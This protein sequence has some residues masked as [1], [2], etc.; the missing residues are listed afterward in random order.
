MNEIL[1]KSQ[2]RRSFLKYV[3]AGVALSMAG[4]RS[5][6]QT[7]FLFGLAV[8]T[9]T[10][11]GAAAE[12]AARLAVDEVNAAGGVLGTPLDVIVEDSGGRGDQ[13]L[14]SVQA[15]ASRGAGFMGGFFFSEELIGAIPALQTSGKLFLGTGA[16]TPV[17]TINIAT[18]Y[19]KN[20]NFFRV[21]P[22]NSFFI[23]QEAVTFTI[24]LLEHGLG[25]DGIVLF[26]ED[27]AWNKPITDSFAKLLAAFGSKVQVADVIRYNEGTT[28]FTPLF[29]QAVA[30]M[31]GKKG[32]LFAVMAHTGTR[33]T[34][35]W[36][37]Q[38][39]P[40]PL[41]GINVQAQDGQF[42]ALTSGASQSVVTFSAASRAPITSLTIPFVDAFSNYSFNP[43][44]NVPSYNAYY[45]YD[46]IRLFKTVAQAVGTLPTSAA[47]LGAIITELESYNKDKT[48]LATTGNLSFFS[49]GETGVSPIAPQYAFP[50]DL[51]FGGSYGDGVWIQWQNGKQEV[52][53][54]PKAPDGQ[55]GLITAAFALP[56]WL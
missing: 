8:P 20:K 30:S 26:A 23:L 28:D 5:F 27:A 48:F 53:F 10:Y 56:P 38:Q 18:D 13:A 41:V 34:S 7:P 52:I 12:K 39:V 14:L 21:G 43:G 42:D 35:Q 4:F 31:K 37:S 19:D 25:W 22:A 29:N 46:A 1:T 36:A 16:S 40:L 24:G 33:P 17:A 3:G 45:T 55:T 47:N 15:L 44:V 50:H 51:R 2:S 6:A 32:G 9:S 54:P 11:F 49:Q